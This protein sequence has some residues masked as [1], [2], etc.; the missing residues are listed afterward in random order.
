MDT[1]GL[2]LGLARG[3]HLAAVLSLFGALLHGCVVVRPACA[4]ADPGAVAALDRA[5]RRLA[6]GSLT[7]ALLA[8][9]V[10]LPLLAGSMAGE[11]RPDAILSAMPVVLGETRFG[12][13][14]LVRLALLL[15]AGVLIGLGRP[16]SALLAAGLALVAQSWMGHPGASD[17]AWLLAASVPH[18]LA[19]GAWLGGLLPLSLAVRTLPGSGAARAAERFFWVALPAVLV[20]AVTAFAQGWLLIGGVGALFTSAYGELA[21]LKLT[22]LLVLLV[23]AAIN[24]FRLTPALAGADAVRAK[25]RLSSSIVVGTLI[26][27]GVVFAAGTLATMAPAAYGAPL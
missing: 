22:G 16:R 5:L 2:A 26:G 17:N 19:A 12:Q 4:G 7:V 25:A 6:W 10:W 20:L 13:A 11:Y 27:L 23:L 24:R 14:F 18:V 21:L 9:A 1:L 3:L 8:A 15:V